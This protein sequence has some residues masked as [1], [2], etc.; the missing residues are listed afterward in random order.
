MRLSEVT[1]TI[2]K[3]RK[4]WYTK[5]GWWVVIILI[6]PPIALWCMTPYGFWSFFG[7]LVLG[8]FYGRGR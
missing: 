8:L 7:A 3:P 5:P 6:T 4:P 1:K 2:K